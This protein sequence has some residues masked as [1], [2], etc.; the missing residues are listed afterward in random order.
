MSAAKE[1]GTDAPIV[2]DSSEPAFWCET[3]IF[4]HIYKEQHKYGTEGCFYV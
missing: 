2:A 3:G 4:L 1:T